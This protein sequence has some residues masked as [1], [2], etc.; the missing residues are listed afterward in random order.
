MTLSETVH[1]ALGFYVYRLVD[2]RNG[3]TFY[4]GKGKGN[5]VLDHTQNALNGKPDTS[6]KSSRIIDILNDGSEPLYIIHRHGLSEEVAYEVEGALIDAYPGLTNDQEGHNNSERGVMS[7]TQV[8]SLYDLQEMPEPD[9]PALVI[10][11]NNLENRRDRASVYNQVKGHWRLNL[12]NARKVNM[13]IAVYKGIAVGVFFVN[14]WYNSPAH[15]GRI[16]FHGEIADETIWN[17]YVGD[18]G[19]RI[20]SE[21]LRNGQNPVKYFFP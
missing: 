11:V 10:N 13:V 3:E 15:D 4:I 18:A 19:K 1:Q 20:I 9:V 16:C 21:Q 17:L 2:P 7:L 8:M 12:D 6:I 5:R 14:E